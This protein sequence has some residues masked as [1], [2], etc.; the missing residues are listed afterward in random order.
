MHIFK[1]NVVCTFNLFNPQNGMSYEDLKR[2]MGQENIAM[3]SVQDVR[4][5]YD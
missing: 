4:Y 5:I 1:K 2:E 3:T